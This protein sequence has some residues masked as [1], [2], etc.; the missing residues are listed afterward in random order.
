[1][2]L[3]RALSPSLQKLKKPANRTVAGCLNRG[4]LFALF[5]WVWLLVLG[6]GLGVGGDAEEGSW[7]RDV[8][9][10]VGQAFR[11]AKRFGC[12]WNFG[13]GRVGGPEHHYCILRLNRAECS[14]AKPS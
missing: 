2:S 14:G 1:M 8:C 9:G 10:L 4:A 13:V 12:G 11:L 5:F 6:D 7:G 3:F